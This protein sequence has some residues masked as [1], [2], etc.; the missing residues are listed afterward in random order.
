MTIFRKTILL[1]SIGLLIYQ[2]R[3]GWNKLSNPDLLEVKTNED[4]QNV[5]PPLI[6][7]CPTGQFQEETLQNYDYTTFRN[8]L[9]GRLSSNL[10]V[11][12]WGAQKNMSF[13]NITNNMIVQ[14]LEVSLNTSEY[15]HERKFHP[16][17]GICWLMRPSF[18][19][20]NVMDLGFTVQ[21]RDRD[22]NES[23]Q[24]NSTKESNTDNVNKKTG[25]DN[26]TEKSSTEN[27]TKDS[28]TENDTDISGTNY[29]TN[30]SGADNGTVLSETHIGTEE[31]GTDNGTEES[32]TDNST[33]LSETDI[34]T[35]ESGTD[36]CTEESGADIGTEE[37][38]AD[39]GTDV[40]GEDKSTEESDNVQRL[41]ASRN[42]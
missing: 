33:V 25:K 5:D 24:E 14:E 34:G 2:L 20:S 4:L 16:Q 38:G 30:Q 27:Y 13:V 22:T 21:L 7:I 29:D 3:T 42:K 6:A 36:S 1:I 8:M 35:E 37:S 19:G 32:R 17:L 40:S 31:S 41:D 18:T 23:E 12:A 26:G 28:S 10:N 11:L 15:F 9:N 39:N